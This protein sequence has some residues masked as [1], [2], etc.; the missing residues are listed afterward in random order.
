MDFAAMSPVGPNA[1]FRAFRHAA[2][3]A[4]GDFA[5]GAFLLIFDS[6]FAP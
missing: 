5:L 2:S 1:G 4:Q 3:F 6:A